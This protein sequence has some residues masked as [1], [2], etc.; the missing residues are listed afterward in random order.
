M[1]NIKHLHVVDMPERLHFVPE[2]AQRKGMKQVEVALRIGATQGLVSRWFAGTVPSTDYLQK[3]ADLFGTDIHGLFRH[4]DEEWI[5]RLLRGRSPAERQ[6]A[7]EML[8]L[9]FK[10]DEDD[11]TGTRG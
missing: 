1:S 2:W 3:L 10:D 5:A 9:L 7:V 8:M 4:P 6:K 11:R